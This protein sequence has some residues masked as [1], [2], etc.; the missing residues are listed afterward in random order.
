[1]TDIIVVG[2]VTKDIIKIPGRPDKT[3]SGGSALYVSAALA[4]LGCSV[5]VITKVAPEDAALLDPLRVLGVEI[6]NRP[7]ATTTVFENSY[8]GDELAERSQRV[9]GQASP[10][11]A[12]DLELKDAAFVYLGP[13]TKDEISAEVIARAAG[14]KRLALDAQGLLRKVV[15]EA[16]QP[17]TP[18]DLG[19]L[20]SGVDILKV[21]DREAQLLLG[22]DKSVAF[23]DVHALLG[24]GVGEVAMT[25]ADRGSLIATVEED[26]TI[27]C[28]RIAAI[29][30]AELV[31]ATG[32][33]D[34]FLAGYLT[35]RIRDERPHQAG[36]FAAACASLKLEGYGPFASTEAQAVQRGQRNA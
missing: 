21:D 25:F 28:H 32:C 5:K 30:P 4:Q 13:L 1:M 14:A 18:E 15:G 26:D 2:H 29:E 8:S 36:R 9:L 7:T 17:H 33:G 19:S 10:F 6:E 20:L 11:T 12:D 31:D 24:A 3:L 35:M 34:T 16:V 23:E 27:K 22:R